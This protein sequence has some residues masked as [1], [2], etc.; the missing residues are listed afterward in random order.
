MIGEI[1]LDD[2]KR[3]PWE[4]MAMSMY[5]LSV[6]TN[7]HERSGKEYEELLTKYDFLDVQYRQSQNPYLPGAVFARKK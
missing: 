4:G 7:A 3:G 1:L 5:M 2:D 6:C